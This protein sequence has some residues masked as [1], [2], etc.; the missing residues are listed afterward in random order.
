MPWNK[1]R[2]NNLA[3]ARNQVPTGHSSEFSVYI[4]Q[5]P[6][7]RSF[8]KVT[9]AKNKEQLWAPFIL[10]KYTSPLLPLFPYATGGKQRLKFHDI[11]SLQVHNT[12]NHMGSSLSF[13]FS[14]PILDCHQQNSSLPTNT[15]FALSYIYGA[16][17]I[18]QN[19]KLVEIIKID[20]MEDAWRQCIHCHSTLTQISTTLKVIVKHYDRDRTP[21][22]LHITNQT[23]FRVFIIRNI[24]WY[25]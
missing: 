21:F 18:Y 24:M 14:V 1:A 2:S 16:Q 9:G 11:N 22:E 20:P 25:V 4:R 7:P 10:D 23:R 15:T 12:A 13:T 6:Q 17:L 19:H 8:S 5:W 3:I